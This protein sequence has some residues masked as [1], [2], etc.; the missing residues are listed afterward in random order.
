MRRTSP[1]DDRRVAPPV[2]IHFAP[3]AKE[4]FAAVI[5]CLAERNRNRCRAAPTAH[6]RHQCQHSLR[7]VE[8][9]RGEAVRSWAVPPVRI[10]Y[11]RHGEVFWVLWH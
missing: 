3:E 9:I 11:Q 1:R 4:D 5:E 6:L 2:T 8:R 7:S 10:Y